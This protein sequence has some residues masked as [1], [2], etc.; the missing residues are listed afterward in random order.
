VGYTSDGTIS[1]CCATG[2]V[3]GVDY[4]GG[5]VGY[6][7]EGT[8]LACFWDITVNP[9]LGGIGDGSNPSVFSETTANMQMEATFT[10]QGWDFAGETA[11]GTDDIW[12]ICE[13]TNYPKLSWQI[14]LL[15]DFLCPDGVSLADFGFFASHWGETNC[16]FSDDCSGADLDGFGSVD[17]NDVGIFFENWLTGI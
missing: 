15:G 5:L 1:N 14:P 12:D 6:S 11:N 10:A 9:F 8:Y 3:S 16:A 2:T 13:G 17:P 7:W 4:V